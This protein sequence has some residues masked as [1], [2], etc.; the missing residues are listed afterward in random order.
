MG[1]ARG[2]TKIIRCQGDWSHSPCPL[3]AS[4]TKPALW[5]ATGCDIY[6]H[7]YRLWV[8]SDPNAT[9]EF[10]G[11]ISSCPGCNGDTLRQPPWY[12]RLDKHRTLGGTARSRW[13]NGRFPAR[14]RLDQ[15]VQIRAKYTKFPLMKSRDSWWI[16]WMWLDLSRVHLPGSQ[17]AWFGR[18]VSLKFSRGRR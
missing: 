9:W 3:K 7:F 16:E 18:Y 2:W 6:S 15:T 13:D 14:P 5:S 17:I 8:A 4:G 1:H 11:L 12:E 10:L